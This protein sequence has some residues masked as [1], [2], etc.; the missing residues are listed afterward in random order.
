MNLSTLIGSLLTV[1]LVV[2]LVIFRLF[3]AGSS[4]AALAGL[5]RLPKLPKSWRRWFFDERNGLS[6]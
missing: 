4:V 3:W 1:V 5:G 6:N 2:G